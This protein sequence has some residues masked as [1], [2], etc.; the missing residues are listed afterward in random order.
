MYVCMYVTVSMFARYELLRCANISIYTVIPGYIW[1]CKS[2]CCVNNFL[3]FTYYLSFREKEGFKRLIDVVH[4]L[5]VC[6]YVC[7]NRKY[8]S[9]YANEIKLLN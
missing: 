5:N 6:M 1:M 9:I 7:V 4:V 3:V 8:G 2:P